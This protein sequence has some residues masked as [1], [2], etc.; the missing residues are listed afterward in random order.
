M[1]CTCGPGLTSPQIGPNVSIPVDAGAD[2]D[3]NEHPAGK[4]GIPPAAR[5]ANG[6][7]MKA[8]VGDE[9]IIESPEPGTS[10]R[11]GTIVALQNA[12]GSPP[13][14][15]HWLAGDYDSLIEPCPA[16]RIG[17]RRTSRPSSG[18]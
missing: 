9:L 13:Y 18:S 14:V 7:V 17:R 2:D 1:W 8:Q 15:V 4:S 10:G 12:D 16:A 11:I 3:D 6:V 5:R